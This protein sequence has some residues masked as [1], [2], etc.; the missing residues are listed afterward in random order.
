MPLKSLFM[1]IKK[2]KIHFI[3]IGGIGM[4]AIA[5]ILHSMNFIISGSDI[6]QNENIEK[7]K[8]LGIKICSNHDASNIEDDF[9]VVVTST[10]IKASNPEILAARQKG[11]TIVHRGEMLAELMRLKYGI[12]IAGT[13]GKT[14]TTS[15]VSHLMTE[16][17]LEPTCVIGGNHF[18]IGSNGVHGDSQYFVCEADES[19]GSFL[20]LSP[21][22]T[23]VTNI[24]NDHLE[25][26]HNMENLSLAFLNFVN[27]VPFYGYSFI[28]YEDDNLRTI[29]RSMK[30]KH[31]SYGFSIECDLYADHIE[32]TSKG[33]KFNATF[34]GKELGCF[35]MSL[36]GIHNVLNALAS[37][38][39]VY[40]LGVEL[41][42]IR[43]AL[44]T[45]EGVGRRLNK[46]SDKNEIIVYDDYAHHPTEI[47]TTLKALKTA[48]ENRRIIAIFQPHRY[49]RTEALFVDFASAFGNV[50]MLIITDIYAAG[51][52]SQND[53]TSM[54]L[55]EEI[56]KNQDNVFYVSDK[57]EVANFLASHI[58]IGDIMITLGA[59][60][61]KNI[62]SDLTSI[63]KNI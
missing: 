46:M 39:V 9:D 19:D 58:K 41:E 18:N 38:G 30:K 32:I 52:S 3:G 60:D 29:V 47:Q 36:I 26:Y 61:I 31:Y 22:V 23:I 33:T 24:D 59:G 27:K 25:H 44:T 43:K 54:T 13:H 48:Y 62:S 10:A 20:E 15:I 56:K 5:K 6:S 11:I 45:F 16:A 17:S 40:E 12:A 21:V 49:S 63:T 42:D 4:S 55:V 28:C 2:E 7:L 50:D 51:E 8:A 34:L 14:T 37:I 57:N 1:F 35:E 53:I